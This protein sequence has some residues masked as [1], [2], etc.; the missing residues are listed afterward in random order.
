[1]RANVI[2]VDETTRMVELPP[3][4]QAPEPQGLASSDTPWPVLPDEALHGVAGDIVQLATTDSEVDPAAVLLTTLTMAAATIG[5]D[6]FVLIGDTRHPPRVSTTL[7]GES[8]RARKGTSYSP[9]RRIFQQTH[10]VL[11]ESSGVPYPLGAELRISD[12][13]L[14]SGEG[15]VYAVRDESETQDQEGNPV[16]PGVK[17]KRLFVIEGEFAAALKAVQR[18]GNTLSAILRTAWDHGNIEPLTKS[19]RIKATGAHINFVAHITNSELRLLL[20]SADIWNGFANRILWAAVRRTKRVPFPAPMPEDDVATI[21]HRLARSLKHACDGR[22]REMEA[23]AKKKWAR[24]YG[25]LTEDRSGVLGAVTSRAEAQVI[26]LALLYSLLDPEAE[27]IETDHLRA[28]L[29]VWQYCDESAAYIFGQAETD[30]EA[31][32]ILEALQTKELTR[33]EINRLFAGHISTT[34]L[35]EILERLQALGK[36]TCRNEG[37]G[38]G[39][40]RP[41]T[42]WGLTSQRDI[43]EKADFAK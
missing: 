38:Q 39:Q 34:R 29:G 37:G 40:G 28:A 20:R 8:S 5:P 1:M 9:V 3:V 6:Q 21:A 36:V 10:K 16:D 15:L 24:I 32:K 30:P 26:R 27:Q 25:E 13:P 31:N 14:S 18:D 11:G 22:P 2:H 7:V 33:T 43:A 12:G 41:K 4:I 23:E 17:D 35:A 19:N 42:I